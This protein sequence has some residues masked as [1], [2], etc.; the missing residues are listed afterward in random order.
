MTPA[1][2]DFEKQALRDRIV[3]I[4]AVRLPL[5]KPALDDPELR[6]ELDGLDRERDDI[7]NRLT[8][9][10]AEHPHRSWSDAVSYI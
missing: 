5:F 1:L 2:T 10:L 3:A 9:D 7:T 8:R 6:A 4:D